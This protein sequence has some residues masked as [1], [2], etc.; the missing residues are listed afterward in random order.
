MISVVATTEPLRL[1][2]SRAS[3]TMFCQRQNAPT[4]GASAAAAVLAAPKNL[5]TPRSSS[6]SRL[7]SNSTRKM[8]EEPFPVKLYK[9]LEEAHDIGG[10]EVIGW[11]SCGKKFL[12]HQPKVFAETWMVRHFNQSKYKSFQ[13]QLNLYNFH[14]QSRGKIKGVCK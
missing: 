2:E 1:A 10:Q 5:V 14:R 12:V 6:F 9:M 4:A 3:G 13:R 11:S 8:N 7:T